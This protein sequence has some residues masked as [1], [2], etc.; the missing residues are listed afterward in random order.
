MKAYAF[1][2]GHVTGFFSIGADLQG[3]I[4]A[5]FCVEK[6]VKTTVKAKTS[7]T[8][9]LE[10]AL[11]GHTNRLPTSHAVVRKYLELSEKPRSLSI[12]HKAELPVGYG[13]GMSGAGA[14]SLS[15]ALNKALKTRLSAL[16]CAK[17]AHEAE[18]ECGTGL[19]TVVAERFGGFGVRTEPG[20]F[21]KYERIKFS[22][23]LKAVLAPLAPLDTSNIIRDEG[24]QTRIM[25]IG[26]ACVRDL[27]R[28]PKA[29]QFITLSRLFATESGLAEGQVLNAMNASGGSMAMLGRS[30]FV[31]TEKPRNAVSILKNYCKKVIV[32][33]ISTKGARLI[34]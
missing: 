32:T 29:E 28:N 22:N 15:L 25:G 34:K 19:G 11:N 21:E 12:V 24:W 2:P 33:K 4:G 5:G 26:R 30:V 9:K 27:L 17:I 6:G 3:S 18:I 31:L 13:F 10:L 16:E 8:N 1:S 23:K 7:K 20:D 14:L